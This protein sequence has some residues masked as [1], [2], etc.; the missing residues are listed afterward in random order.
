MIQS[1]HVV[2]RV[3]KGDDV[4]VIVRVIKGDDVVIRVINGI[5]P[6][7]TARH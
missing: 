2:I 6:C 3:I 4:R 7:G 5:Q 1:E